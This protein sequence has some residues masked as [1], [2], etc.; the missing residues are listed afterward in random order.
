MND[1]IEITINTDVFPDG[2]IVQTFMLNEYTMLFRQTINVHEPHFVEAMVK[3]GWTPPVKEGG[4][5]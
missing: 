3:L 1:K 2:I 5:G 4:N